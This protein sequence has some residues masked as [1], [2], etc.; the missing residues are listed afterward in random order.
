[1]NVYAWVAV[2]VAVYSVCVI[3]LVAFFSVAMRPMSLTACL[4]RELARAA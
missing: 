2:A 1:M 4:D 3:L